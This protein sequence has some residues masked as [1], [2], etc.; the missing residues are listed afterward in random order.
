MLMQIGHIELKTNLKSTLKPMGHIRP[1]QTWKQ[2]EK[3]HF[4]YPYS[5]QLTSQYFML[6]P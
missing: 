1:K 6:F 5:P 4:A 2:N 3:D